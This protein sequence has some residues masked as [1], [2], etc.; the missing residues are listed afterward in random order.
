M[1]TLKDKTAQPEFSVSYA[2]A[3][4][5]RTRFLDEPGVTLVPMSS[6]YEQDGGKGLHIAYAEGDSPFG[7][8]SLATTA[9]GICACQFMADDTLPG[10]ALATLKSQW[11]QA[12]FYQNAQTQTDLNHLIRQWFGSGRNT[13]TEK[14][15]LSLHVKG[16]PFQIQVWQAL[17]SIP[18]GGL[19]SYGDIAQRI[20]KTTQASRA[21]GTAIGQNAVAFLIPCH[22]VLRGS[23]AL[24][25]YRWGISRKKHLLSWEAHRLCDLA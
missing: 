22:R 18:A 12:T 6:E 17:L 14:Q 4:M 20:G 3:Q 1:N 11:P 13:E 19:Q 7:R 8:I 24:G 23:G 25:G 2:R 16:S 9:Q 5:A 21:V 10:S 15:A